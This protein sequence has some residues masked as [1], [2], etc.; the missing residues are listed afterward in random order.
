MQTLSTTVRTNGKEITLRRL[1]PEVSSDH[2][3]E[4]AMSGLAVTFDCPNRAACYEASKV[5][6]EAVYGLRKRASLRGR[7][8]NEINAANSDICEITDLI[9]VVA[10]C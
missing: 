6:C 8:G 9:E 5:V 2:N 10:G 4:V 7:G 3:V 1:S